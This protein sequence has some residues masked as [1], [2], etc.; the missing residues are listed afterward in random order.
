MQ[1]ELTTVL[2]FEKYNSHRPFAIIAAM[3]HA[4]E[5]FKNFRSTPIIVFENN[6]TGPI[7]LMAFQIA[8]AALLSACNSLAGRLHWEILVSL[9]REILLSFQNNPAIY[10]GLLHL[11]RFVLHREKVFCAQQ[12]IKCRN[13]TI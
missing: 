12:P 10:F 13:K 2:Y 4:L 5:S 6:E 11:I 9:H 7:R 1:L 3:G 8:N